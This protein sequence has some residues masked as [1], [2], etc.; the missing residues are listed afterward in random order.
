MTDE[1]VKKRYLIAKKDEHGNFLGFEFKPTPKMITI[2]Y[3]SVNPK[4]THMS[5]REILKHRNIPYVQWKNW[6][7]NF[8]DKIEHKDP[9][10]KEIT[11]E[12]RNWFVEWW[13]EELDRSQINFQQALAHVGFKKAMEGDHRFWKDMS[14]TIGVVT[15]EAKESPQIEIPSNLGKEEATLDDIRIAKHKLLSLHRGLVDT[16]PANVAQTLLG[17][18]KGPAPGAD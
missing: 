14:R 2:L 18:P 4:Y 3:D 13:T 15:N 9:V 7:E 1:L 5:I 8:I 6:Q 12:E 10:T 16:G 11:V 17:K